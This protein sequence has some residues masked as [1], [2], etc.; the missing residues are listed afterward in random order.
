MPFRILVAD[1]KIDD[2]GEEISEL[3][4]LLRRAGYEVRTAAA[5]LPG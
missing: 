2:R 3:P 1:D 5:A 4:E